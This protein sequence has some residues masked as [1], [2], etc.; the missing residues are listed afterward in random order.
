MKDILIDISGKL[1]NSYIAAIKEIKKI[2]DSLKIPFFIIGALARDIIM[3]YFYEIKAPRMTMDIDLGIRVSSWNQFD[4]LI[5][6]LEL[7]GDFKK[8]KE[9]HRVIYKDIIID[10]VPF[11]SISDKNE[12]ISWPPENEVV[13]SVIGFNEVYNNS[14]LVR[15][16]NNPILDVKIP[17]L[18]GLAILKLIAWKDNYPNR[19][20]DAED[21]LFIMKNYESAGISDKLY[22]TELQLLESEDFDIQIAGIVLLGK[23]MS[24]ICKN[25]TIEYLRK[26]IDEETSENSNYN[27][28]KDMLLTKRGDFNRILFLLRK[29][30][31]GIYNKSGKKI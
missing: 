25:K 6:T 15:L 9:R 24:K 14:T 20:K 19:S 27:L 22:E 8:L 16:Q 21:L 11:G 17:T 12:K 5:N 4:Q 31:D 7:S 10:I 13:M 2:A 1:D 26:I 23:E 29:L 18:P 28:I 30:K 3:E